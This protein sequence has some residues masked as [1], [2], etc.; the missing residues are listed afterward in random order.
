[1]NE[2]EMEIR[3]EQKTVDAEMVIVKETVVSAMEPGKQKLK[4]WLEEEV[5]LPQYYELFISNGIE[6]LE[7][8]A[9]LTMTTIKGIGVDLIGHQIKILNEVNKLNQNNN[10]KK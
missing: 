7:T 3:G 8:V 10:G 4:L 1:M 5:K 6:D 2:I 9:L